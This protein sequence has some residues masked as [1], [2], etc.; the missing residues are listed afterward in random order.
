MPQLTKREALAV[1]ELLWNGTPPGKVAIWSG[2]RPPSITAIIKGMAHADVEWPDG[3]TG[4]MNSQRRAEVQRNYGVRQERIPKPPSLQEYKQIATA[5]T[6]QRPGNI[7]QWR[8]E[9]ENPVLTPADVA[10]A[11]RLAREHMARKEQQEQQINQLA[12]TVA[13]EQEEE[14]LKGIT[15]ISDEDRPS[16]EAPQVQLENMPRIPWSEIQ[17]LQDNPLIALASIDEELQKT[18]EIA[19]ASMD[20]E[21]WY[22]QYAW[23]TADHIHGIRGH[24]PLRP[25]EMKPAKMRPNARDAIKSQKQQKAFD[26]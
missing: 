3:S 22:T 1:K 7:P 15:S 17:H 8:P 12:A 9:E 24:I 20:R 26:N 16:F 4:P 6:P 25:M 18:L 14:F 23:K 19:F 2:V 5:Q 11:A 13:H 10:R 21:H